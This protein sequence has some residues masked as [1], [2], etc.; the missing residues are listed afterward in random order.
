MISSLRLWIIRGQQEEVGQLRLGRELANVKR[1]LAADVLDH[2]FTVSRR[3]IRYAA[4]ACVQQDA[5]G[6]LQAAVGH[7]FDSLP[8]EQPVLSA[9]IRAQHIHSLTV[10]CAPLPSAEQQAGYVRFLTVAQHAED[11]AERAV[12]LIAAANEQEAA[13]DRRIGIRKL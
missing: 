2:A 4:V 12:L 11:S 10:A 6:I 8:V 5:H 7:P 1:G 3:C 13:I 9:L